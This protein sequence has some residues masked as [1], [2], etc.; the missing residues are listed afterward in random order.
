MTLTWTAPAQADYWDAY[1]DWM[2]LM[3]ERREALLPPDPDGHLW[4]EPIFVRLL[5]GTGAIESARTALQALVDDPASPFVMDPQEYARLTAR[6]THP[7][8]NAGLPDDYALYRRKGTDMA[9]YADLLFLMDVGVAVDLDADV[10]SAATE[11][12]QPVIKPD[13]DD[14]DEAADLAARAAKRPIIAVMDDGIGFLNARFRRKRK[15]RDGYK[16]R[17]QALWL[18]SL[19]KSRDLPGPRRAYV[20]T[21]LTKSDINTWLGDLP[22]LDESA[23]Y[24][25]LNAQLFPERGHRTTDFSRS[26]GTVV[27]DLAAG[28]DPDDSDDPVGKWPLLGVQLPPQAIADTSGTHF[29]SYMVQ[30]MRWILAQAAQ[31]NPK[32]PVIVNI[33]LGMLAGPKDGTRFTE[34]QISQEAMNWQAVTGQPVRVVWSFGN[35]RLSRQV[36]RFDY[37]TANPRHATDRGIVWRAQP[38]DLTP[39]YM[40]VR[41]DPDTPTEDLQVHLTAPDGTSSGFA[42]MAPGQ[43]RTLEKDGTAV[44]RIYLNPAHELSTSTTQRPFYLLALAPTNTLLAGDTLAPSGGWEVAVRHAGPAAATVHLQIQRGDSL[45]SYEPQGRQ[46]YFDSPDAYAW[47]PQM[48]NYWGLEPDCPITRDATHSALVTAVNRQVF[49]VGAA[50]GAPAYDAFHAPLYTSVGSDW[51]VPAPTVST[52]ADTTRIHWGVLASGTISGSVVAL[53]GTSAAAGRLSRAL[54]L[55]AA[56]IIANSQAGGGSQIDDLDPNV[57]TLDPVDPALQPQLGA[58]VVTGEGGARPR[59]L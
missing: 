7:Q 45:P 10:P 56:R 50:E 8:Q 16:T 33:S 49:S 37:D 58:C 28:A 57:L 30:G 12:S 17:F 31:I 26:H 34:Y 18:Q 13:D 48:Q 44:A 21:V 54:G 24:S 40:E 14:A 46:S 15:T 42:A 59:H 36:A 23:V 3:Q 4:Y 1:L 2:W 5:P 38:D 29:E 6:I 53:N 22:S 9:P 27:M 11:M 35:N 55:S 39:S 41:T 43:V 32:A 52:V 25:Q 20:G 47:D 19:E 51:S